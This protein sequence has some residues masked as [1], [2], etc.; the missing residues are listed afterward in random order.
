MEARRLAITRAGH[1]AVLVAAI[2]VIASACGSAEPTSTATR[3]VAPASTTAPTDDGCGRW[4]R[5]DVVAPDLAAAADAVRAVLGRDFPLVPPSVQIDHATPPRIRVQVSG[6]RDEIEADARAAIDPK[7]AARL[8]VELIQADPQSRM[9]QVFAQLGEFLKTSP[10]PLSD[11]GT[12][13][14]G[15]EIIIELNRETHACE[16][17]DAIAQRFPTD[18][19][20]VKVW[21][22]ASLADE[23]NDF[24]GMWLLSDT[25]VSRGERLQLELRTDGTFQMRDRCNYKAG[26]WRIDHNA[27]K[28]IAFTDVAITAMA[29]PSRP[30]VLDVPR[31]AQIDTNGELLVEETAGRRL[32]YTRA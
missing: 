27:T 26:R 8:L 16:L 3:D 13:S 32:V 11:I 30:D 9:N 1:V 21:P 7:L 5:D 31:G 12:V 10:A 2:G 18:P 28:T 6:Q 25:A 19:V 23:G 17:A 20:F 4:L 22:P 24:F 14:L 29:C 15:I